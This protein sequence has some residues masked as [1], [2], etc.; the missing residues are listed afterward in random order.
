MLVM[1]PAKY[2]FYPEFPET[3]KSVDNPQQ[4]GE[5]WQEDVTAANTNR[6]RC[7]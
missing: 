2:W 5:P 1:R 6:K 3:S 7:S 4:R